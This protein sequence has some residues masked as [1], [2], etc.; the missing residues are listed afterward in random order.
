VRPLPLIVAD[1]LD[2]LLQQ[3]VLAILTIADFPQQRNDGGLVR[4]PGRRSR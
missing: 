4:I 2:Q 1:H 3:L